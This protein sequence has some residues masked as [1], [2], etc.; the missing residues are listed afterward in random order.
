[1]T[2]HKAHLFDYAYTILCYI[3]LFHLIIHLFYGTGVLL[4]ITYYQL[5][6]IPGTVPVNLLKLV[7]MNMNTPFR[8]RVAAFNFQLY[9]YRPFYSF[10]SAS[11]WCFTLYHILLT[12]IS[13]TVPVNLFKLVLM[14][15]NM[16]FRCRVVAF[17]FQLY[18]YSLFTTSILISYP[19]IYIYRHRFTSVLHSTSDFVLLS[20]LLQLFPIEL[21]CASLF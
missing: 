21:Y 9:S 3:S 16:P 17:N 8:R 18:V 19:F 15:M 5:F 6:F 10:F 2:I 1:L 11:L 12:F 20:S 7:L 4:C 14:N 13:G